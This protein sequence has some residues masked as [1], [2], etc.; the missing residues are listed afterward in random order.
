M[1][2][3]RAWD[4]CPSIDDVITTTEAYDTSNADD[5]D[6]HLMKRRNIKGICIHKLPGRNNRLKAAIYPTVHDTVACKLCGQSFSSTIYKPDYVQSVCNQFAEF[7]WAI[8]RSIEQ[9]YL[10]AYDVIKIRELKD[11]VIGF[12][13]QYKY[14]YRYKHGMA[15]GFDTD[16][17]LTAFGRP[18]YYM[19]K[20][21]ELDASINIEDMIASAES[22]I[23]IINQFIYVIQQRVPKAV[24]REFLCIKVDICSFLKLYTFK[25]VECRKRPSASKEQNNRE[26]MCEKKCLVG[27]PV[28]NSIIKSPAAPN[29]KF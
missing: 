29:E 17:L 7:L 2:K 24:L 25:I 12:S 26:I 9:W 3:D 18:K 4:I 1:K 8:D 13:N 6:V 27:I 22:L 11:R 19:N 14:S 23:T 28:I 15:H 5:D 20:N 21:I 16:M 10:P